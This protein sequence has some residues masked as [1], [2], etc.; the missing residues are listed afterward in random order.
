MKFIINK[1]KFLEGVSLTE[2]GVGKNLS[3][4]VLGC[5]LLDLKGNL[6]TIRS[7]NL[8]LG[9]EARVSVEGERDGVVA[10]PANLLKGF[11]SNIQKESEIVV[12][13]V[14]NLLTVTT[15]HTSSEIKTLPHEDF[16]TLPSVDGDTVHID[17]RDLISGLQSVYYSASISSIKP[18]LSSVYV[19]TEESFLVFVATDSFR[20]AEKKVLLKKPIEIEQILI[21]GKNVAEIIRLFHDVSG[22]VELSFSNEQIAFRRGDLYI[23][24]RIIDGIFPDY[25]QILPKGSQTEVVVL[26]EDLISALKMSSL[27]ADKFFKVTFTIDPEAKEFSIQTQ[28]NDVGNTNV[29]V[30][31]ALSGESIVI[32]YSYKYIVDCFQSIPQDSVSLEFNGLGKPL[33][34]RGVSNKDFLYL[35]M[36]MNR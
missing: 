2:R 6:L 29:K 36:P 20:L 8:D 4:P 35:V 3:L 30:D 34:V 13:V 27:F 12:E 18:E 17:A 24:S 19:Y 21:P 11:I 7:T 9:I 32:Y 10:I 14:E 23:T 15:P 28:N 31:A 26:K 22:E 16:P 33:V 25:K 5:L 1:E